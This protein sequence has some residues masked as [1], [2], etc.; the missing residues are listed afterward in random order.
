MKHKLEKE[1][2]YFLKNQEKLIKEY[3]G[4]YIVIKG[5]KILDIYDNQ[6]DA[7]LNTKE[8]EEAGTFLIQHCIPGNEEY[9][10][11]FHSRVFF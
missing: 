4:K 5:N 8:S 11:Y 7:Y 2:N 9:T 1:F 6:L 10:H 3:P